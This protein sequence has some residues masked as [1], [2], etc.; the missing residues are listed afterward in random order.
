MKQTPNFTNWS[1]IILHR[2]DSSLDRLVRQLKLFGF[3]VKT[4]W[5]P[6]S[7]AAVPDLVLVDADQGW[8]GLLPWTAP[9][10]ASCPVVALLG[11]EAP[12][13]IAWAYDQGAGAILAKPLN[14]SAIYPALVMAIAVHQ[15]RQ[16]VRDQIVRLEERARLRPLVL[17]AVKVLAAAKKITEAKAYALLRNSAMGQRQPVEV[18]AAAFLSGNHTIPEAGRCR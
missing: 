1:A 5:E 11:S 12:S 2:P 6:L 7:P 15:E 10:H 14:T 13:R 16:N 4:K 9:D 17:N 3:L 8:P 18:V